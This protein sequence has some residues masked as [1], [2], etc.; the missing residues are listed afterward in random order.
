MPESKKV[1]NDYSACKFRT[2]LTNLP[3]GIQHM[4][5]RA[6]DS[7][8]T[9]PN[10]L[11]RWTGPVVLA[12]GSTVL[13]KDYFPHIPTDICC[14]D[15]TAFVLYQSGVVDLGRDKD[16]FRARMMNGKS[17]AGTIH[18][19]H[20]YHAH[21]DNE[22]R[23]YALPK[24]ENTADPSSIDFR[25]WLPGDVF[26]Y[27]NK[28]EPN[29]P[30]GDHVNIY[31]G[32]FIE[33]VDGVDIPQP[34]Y[35]MFNSSIGLDGG[36]FFCKPGPFAGHLAYC[37][38]VGRSMERIRV[39]AI[40]QLFRNQ[41]AAPLV[42][43]DATPKPG[44][45]PR[46]ETAWRLAEA[47]AAPYPIGRAMTWH[48]GIHLVS[49]SGL[50]SNAIECF[51]PGELVLVRF[52]KPTRGGDSSM[53]LVRHRV[54]PLQA[55]LL[56]SPPPE[57]KDDDPA[58]KDAKPLY[59][60]YM[61]LAPLSTYLDEG[62]EIEPGIPALYDGRDGASPPPGHA[63]APEWLR[64]LW[65]Q[66]K[67]ALIDL[68][69]DTAQLTLLAVTRAGPGA[70]PK[71][72]PIARPRNLT[73]RRS[74]PLSELE[75]LTIDGTKYWLL[76]VPG[77]TTNADVWDMSIPPATVPKARKLAYYNP[78]TEQAFDTT[79]VVSAATILAHRAAGDV[80]TLVRV[81]KD[82]G[83]AVTGPGG[84]LIALV[85]HAS[86]GIIMNG[87]IDAPGDKDQYDYDEATQTLVFHANVKA[88][89]V[90]TETVGAA[91]K[92]SFGDEH[93]F[94]FVKTGMERTF[95][96]L[97]RANTGSRTRYPRV[98][99]DL[100]PGVWMTDDEIAKAEQLLADRDT[101]LRSAIKARLSAKRSCLVGVKTNAKS[102]WKLESGHLSASDDPPEDGLVTIYRKITGKGS[103]RAFTELPKN[104]SEDQ[105][106][107]IV[108]EIE[109]PAADVSIH[110]LL[111]PEKGVQSAVF[112]L[113]FAT[114]ITG[115]NQAEIDAIH[116]ANQRKKPLT[117]KLLAGTL[118]DLRSES[119][120]D[121]LA[122]NVGR[123]RFGEMGLVPGPVDG[124]GMVKGVH[125][126]LF[127]GENLVDPAVTGTDGAI[128]PVPKTPW[129][130][131]KDTAPGGFF[132][133]EFVQKVVEL[134][135]S[136]SANHRIDLAA[137][138]LA[139][140]ADGVVQPDEW[141]AFCSKN[142]R[143]LS[144]LISVHKPE[145]KT[146]WS[147][148]VGPDTRG[149]HMGAKDKEALAADVAE[150]RW[151]K[152]DL[153][154][155]GIAGD[156]VFFYHP[157][158]F[159]EWIN[160]GI[161]F[162]IAGEG[163][164]KPKVKVQPLEGG[165]E[166][167]LT[168][169]ARVPGLFRYRTFVGEGGAKTEAPIRVTLENV[170]TATPRF[171]VMV[172]R[173]ELHT[174]RLIQP[175]VSQSIESPK[176]SIAAEYHVPVALGDPR[177][178]F[179][180]ADGNAHLEKCGYDETT[181]A[182]K[183]SYNVRIPN[184]VSLK[185]EGDA[186]FRIYGHEVNGAKATP[187]PPPTAREITL[188]LSDDA[189]IAP[190][191][192]S[193][194]VEGSRMYTLRVNATSA[195]TDVDK[196]AKLVV[197]FSGGDLA[198]ERK[199][200]VPLATRTLAM[201]KKSP[202]KGED[203]AKL[204]LYLSQIHADD[205][206][207]C[208]RQTAKG[209][210]ADPQK[211]GA[212]VIDGDY[213]KG[214]ARALWRFIYTY[215]RLPGWSAF[216]VATTKSDGTDG[217]AVSQ[218]EVTGV[219]A[220]LLEGKTPTKVPDGSS[221]ADELYAKRVGAFEKKYDH[222]PVVGKALLVEVTKRFRPPFVLPH[223]EVFFEQTAVAAPGDHAV[224]S[225]DWNKDGRIGKSTLLPLSGDTC[226][227]RIAW[228][229]ADA[230]RDGDLPLVIEVPEASAYRFLQPTPSTKIETTLR[231]VVAQ[232]VFTLYSSQKISTKPADNVLVVRTRDGRK[233]GERQLHGSRDL[234]KAQAGDG[235][236]DAAL[237]QSWLARIADATKPEEK[238]YK[239]TVQV[240]KGKDAVT[241]L[242]IDGKWNA[243]CVEALK[244]FQ[245][246]YAPAAADFPALVAA[247]RTK[248]QATP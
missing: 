140:G 157:L 87:Y 86:P 186:S 175:S 160:T 193:S 230:Q 51:A 110:P 41:I 8:G 243:K 137:L 60:L 159:I 80:A 238:V 228:K 139:F 58:A 15:G 73:A 111:V 189:T 38:S 148:E 207:P 225:P 204:Q 150:T 122:R 213:G 26:V 77:G 43:S 144:R 17:M 129:L 100:K 194:V 171:T 224:V 233:I 10:V 99:L 180:L 75:S 82:D 187:T 27:Y 67:P 169:D 56:G 226:Q 57:A 166:I 202:P 178:G 209:E 146:D 218:A 44:D 119:D 156:D 134:L 158:R 216:P 6:L 109:P 205:D 124:P 34:V 120:V 95:H 168:P 102:G 211:L 167:E 83:T 105:E 130:V 37:K 236:R 12:N 136:E 152:D 248:A 123:D 81:T 22:D 172:K 54:V 184:K 196:S 96:V 103:K 212:A 4:L 115:T 220:S 206:L 128:V 174:V 145:W 85:A 154:L 91:E 191:V 142:H 221:S 36:N 192:E 25:D 2:L 90:Y 235:C 208:Y 52:G 94:D 121:Q 53:V 101:V 245:T 135:R 147:A 69:P 231:K 112:E 161:D 153:S 138:E 19:A 78:L 3:A 33:V 89:T 107:S 176:S 126:E 232:P 9:D 125:F 116:Q 219:S 1:G 240:G 155:E 7:F 39:K 88:I 237:V 28:D 30:E 198:A 97:D 64:K 210:N 114:T 68:V 20:Y 59:S 201:G 242:S 246:Q 66:R 127:A 47:G 227:V 164:K 21:K 149:A 49:G 113:I 217:A 18:W 182:F 63:S 223:I 173:G 74:Y 13:E 35:H 244:R 185:L 11:Q 151:W 46:A 165:G 79:V 40:E 62:H 24:I 181:V 104:T 131:H 5:D 215:G 234:L 117:K 132:S 195:T 23:V 93:K 106:Q 199:I 42:L 65:L 203:I 108:F 188:E 118:V 170:D 214:L 76:P 55:R 31:L 190:L 71:L 70:S 162:V 32:P 29:D 84:T 183:V 98:W 163:G 16:F 141:L 48:E 197:T 50:A 179:V 92:R 239:N 222:F 61:Q 177:G 247:L 229:G 72:T 14:A 143:S 45:P 133:S 241:K 200:E